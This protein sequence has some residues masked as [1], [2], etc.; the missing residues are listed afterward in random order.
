MVGYGADKNYDV[1][2][3]IKSAPNPPYDLR[4]RLKIIKY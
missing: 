4:K 1:F 3:K 2:I